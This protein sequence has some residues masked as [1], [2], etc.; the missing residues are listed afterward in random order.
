MNYLDYPRSRYTN[1]K[2]RPNTYHSQIPPFIPNV[3]CSKLP[4]ISC[5]RACQQCRECNGSP[6][7][8]CQHKCYQCQDCISKQKIDIQPLTPQFYNRFPIQPEGYEEL[9]F[10]T[11]MKCSDLFNENECN[12]FKNNM[13]GYKKCVKCRENGCWKDGQCHKKA[14]FE[15]CDT[16]VCEKEFGFPFNNN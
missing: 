11:Y 10:D 5:V 4:Q 3:Q 12:T 16:W 8:D 9:I 2:S 15:K 14:P 6:I 1:K 13:T 7:Y